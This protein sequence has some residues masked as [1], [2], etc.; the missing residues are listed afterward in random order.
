MC[1]K[2]EYNLEKNY[3]KTKAFKNQPL[4]T[5]LIILLPQTMITLI[6]FFYEVSVQ[7]FCPPF[8][9]AC[10]FFL[11]I[12]RNYLYILD[13]SHFFDICIEFFV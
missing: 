8:L 11:V 9:C 2:S 4:N 12:D 6:Y 13:T 5:N 3:I 1:N 10:L 7:V